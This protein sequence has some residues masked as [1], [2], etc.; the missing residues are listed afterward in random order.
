MNLSLYLIAQHVAIAHGCLEVF[1]F[2]GD[3]C[4]G[5]GGGGG[6]GGGDGGCY[7]VASGGGRRGAE[8]EDRV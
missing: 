4:V 3:L 6:V 2:E 5:A 7:A 1:H 8:D